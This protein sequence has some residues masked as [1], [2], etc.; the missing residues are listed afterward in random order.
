VNSAQ[1]FIHLIFSRVVCDALNVLAVTL[2]S[3][4]TASTARRRS[5]ATPA[6]FALTWLLR[7]KLLGLEGFAVLFVASLVVLASPAR[8]RAATTAFLHLRTREIDARVRTQ[9]SCVWFAVAKVQCEDRPVCD[10]RWLDCNF[11]PISRL[12]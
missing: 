10:A 8:A 11:V 2:G 6:A 7:H 12:L 4:S 9:E 1:I 3:S 5:A